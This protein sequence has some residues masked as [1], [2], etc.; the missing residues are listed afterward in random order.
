MLYLTTPPPF[1][2]LIK[3]QEAGIGVI[4]SG[5]GT[6]D[7]KWPYWAM[8]NGCFSAGNDWNENSWFAWISKMPKTAMWLTIPDAL[9]D[10]E[11]TFQLSKR[12][13][14]ILKDFGVPLAFVGQD[15]MNENIVPWSDI[16]CLFIGGTTDWKLSQGPKWVIEAKSRG[17]ATHAG[18]VNSWS[19]Y[20]LFAEVGCDS[21]DGTLVAFE[22]DA[23]VSTISSWFSRF[24]DIKKQKDQQLSLGL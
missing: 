20:R 1:D 3:Y 18:R 15:G 6:V 13:I 5:R 22:P 10:A 23:A 19:R 8:D 24:E 7:E 16:D 17:L 14:P 11:E 21:A 9:G 4:L 12:W 2:R